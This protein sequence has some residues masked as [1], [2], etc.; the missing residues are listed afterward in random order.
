M[1]TVTAAPAAAVPAIVGVGVVSRAPG[2]G[3]VMTGAAGWTSKVAF[4]VAK[5]PVPHDSHQPA[6]SVRTPGSEPSGSVKVKGSER[7]APAATV[8]PDRVRS[9]AA[10]RA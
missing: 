3:A 4:R 2:A 7:V 6:E 1:R 10:S 8:T 5:G 9:G